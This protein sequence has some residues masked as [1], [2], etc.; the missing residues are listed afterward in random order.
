MDKMVNVDMKIDSVVAIVSVGERPEAARD[1]LEAVEGEEFDGK[2]EIRGR[3]RVIE[4][5]DI[6]L[7]VKG[8]GS[9]E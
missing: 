6:K 4:A 7:W 3:I 8:V 9:V 2:S 1:G 5:V